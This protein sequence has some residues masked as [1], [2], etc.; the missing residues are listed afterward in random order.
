VHCDGLDAHLLARPDDPTGDLAAVCYQNFAYLT[1]KT[2]RRKKAQKPQKE[3]SF[4]CALCAFLR[5]IL[6][7][8]SE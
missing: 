8:N 6:F 5:L 4:I 2:I 7:P 3:T 1:H